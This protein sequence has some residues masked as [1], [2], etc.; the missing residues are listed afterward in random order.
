MRKYRHMLVLCTI[1]LALAS[2]GDSEPE[3][4][5]G[6]TP[7]EPGTEING[8]VWSAGY[9]VSETL[10]KDPEKYGFLHTDS[11]WKL[12]DNVA[13]QLDNC[14][15][16][17]EKDL[18]IIDGEENLVG[19]GSYRTTDTRTVNGHEWML[20]RSALLR[21]YYYGRTTYYVYGNKPMLALK[22]DDPIPQEVLNDPA[23]HGFTKIT[24]WYHKLTFANDQ[25]EAGHMEVWDNGNGMFVA[26]ADFW[27]NTFMEWGTSRNFIYDKDGVYYFPKG[28]SCTVAGSMRTDD[29]QIWIV[30]DGEPSLSKVMFKEPFTYNINSAASSYVPAVGITHTGAIYFDVYD[31]NFSFANCRITT[32]DSWL[33]I[34]HTSISNRRG[35]L[36]DN[37]KQYD[38]TGA[39]ILWANTQNTGYNRTATITLSVNAPDGKT[40]TQNYTVNQTGPKG[41]EGGSGGGG[42]GGGE[43]GSLGA[44]WTQMS[45]SGYAPYYYCP[46]TGK[47]TP[48]TKRSTTITV[49]RN[50]NTGAYKAKWASKYYDA[51]Y[52][53]NR[54][55]IDE[56]IHTAYKNGSKYPITCYDPYYLE[57]IIQ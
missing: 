52:G 17:S 5:P 14:H 29:Y 20:T 35:D 43:G 33:T 57:F 45:A 19:V 9:A 16:N 23:D 10:R 4:T 37:G 31:E 55:K 53:Y 49:Y 51:Q 1:T 3:I 24:C 26:G 7:G 36:Q 2:C 48:A 56:D 30:K 41:T 6:N 13:T 27:H 39:C 11:V 8:Q 54:I 34:A 22:D 25:N 47:T 28:S 46:T 42:E 44:D 38:E 21:V 18:L 12:N 40:Y 15:Y 50:V 32:S